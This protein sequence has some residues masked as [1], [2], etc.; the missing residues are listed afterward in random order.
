MS[1]KKYRN[2]NRK[3]K[4]NRR[5]KQL[6]RLHK[7]DVKDVKDVKD[8]LEKNMAYILNGVKTLNLNIVQ[9]DDKL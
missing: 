9:F 4:Y 3:G 6:K 7:K 2:R 5:K 8:I 1:N